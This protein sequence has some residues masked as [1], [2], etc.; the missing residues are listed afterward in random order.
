MV[1]EPDRAPVHD[2][3]KRSR[4]N[5]EKKVAGA[6]QGSFFIVLGQE[7]AGD[8]GMDLGVNISDRRADPF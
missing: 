8:L 4:I 1:T 7:I 5:L 3:L 6:D 2:R